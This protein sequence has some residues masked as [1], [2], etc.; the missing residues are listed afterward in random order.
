[1]GPRQQATPITVSLKS[2]QEI[3]NGFHQRL[4]W[5]LRSAPLVPPH[6]RAGPSAPQIARA[7]F[8][9]Q[10]R[11]NLDLSAAAVLYLLDTCH[12]SAA[13]LDG[14]R[15]IF[16]AS[17]IEPPTD[18]SWTAELCRHLRSANRKPVT[19]AQLHGKMMKSFADGRLAVTPVH[20][21]LSESMEGSIILAP[22]TVLVAPPYKAE[23]Q[24]DQENAPTVLISVKLKDSTTPLQVEEF[25]KWLITNRPSMAN[26]VKVDVTGYHHTAFSGIMLLRIPVPVWVCLRSDPAYSFVDLVRSGNLAVPPQ[27]SLAER[28][29]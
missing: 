20:S 21:Q 18:N 15:E 26:S 19:V 13:T 29:G 4:T 22:L 2:S 23:V 6:R 14:N 27:F 9:I 25:R 3:I 17:S 8:T 16:A 28:P 5:I 11:A 10:A 24:Q 12:G 1:M 7:D